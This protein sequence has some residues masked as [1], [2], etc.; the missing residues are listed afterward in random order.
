[1]IL[2]RKPTK[3]FVNKLFTQWIATPV[4]EL[5]D[6]SD[7]SLNTIENM[8]EQQYAETD[9]GGGDD[10]GNTEGSETSQNYSRFKISCCII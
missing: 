1:M 7:S 8:F 3:E 2:K 5:A 9:Q 4:K 10:A 6:V